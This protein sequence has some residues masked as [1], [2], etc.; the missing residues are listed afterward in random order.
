MKE[1][2]PDWFKGMTYEEG[3]EVTN[4]FT[5]DVFE[6]NNLELSMYDFIMGSYY[7]FERI[8]QSSTLS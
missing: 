4:P 7:I 5:G 1:Q 3:E 2:L 6:L 8:Q